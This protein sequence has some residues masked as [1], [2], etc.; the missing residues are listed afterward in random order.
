MN[1]L[2][3]VSKSPIIHSHNITIFHSLKNGFPFS[4]MTVLYVNEINT[5]IKKS[6]L[7][8]LNHFQNML[9]LL[10]IA[11]LWTLKKGPINPP[12]QNKSYIHVIIDAFSHSVVTVPIKSNNAKTAIKILL[13]HWIIK[14]G[15][16]IYLVTDRV[17]EYVNKEMVHLWEFV[18]LPGQLILLGQMA[19]LKYKIELLVHISE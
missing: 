16:P 13:H 5:S 10:T 2:T 1:T 11:F 18:I 3:L 19:L 9:R 7:L 8:L 14:F 12:S 17:S 6:K 4:Y 15:P